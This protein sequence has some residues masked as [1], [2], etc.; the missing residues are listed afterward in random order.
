M[1][2][3]RKKIPKALKESVK[4]RQK[5]RCV[6]C[7]EM[8]RH[9]HHVLAF[10]LSGEHLDSKNIVLLCKDH[11]IAFHLGDP[12]TFQAIYEYA[13]YLRFNK[14]PEEKDIVDIANE[15]LKTLKISTPQNIDL[16][17]IE[18]ESSPKL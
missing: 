13:W 7:L 8:G 14:I 5:G 4:E 10:S 15:V 17:K 2:K 1:G 12:E 3:K 11:H 6:A 9:Y 18:K 16:N